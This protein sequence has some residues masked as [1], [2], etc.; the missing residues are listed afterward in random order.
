[1]V[2]QWIED[3]FRLAEGYGWRVISSANGPAKD[4]WRYA[5]TVDGICWAIRCTGE[6]EFWI[7]PDSHHWGNP[8][9]AQG[10]VTGPFL[11]FAAA[12]ATYQLTCNT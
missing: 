12:A 8:P 1:M 4:S 11:S 5:F 7:V 9:S 3:T 2:E 6:H 10:G